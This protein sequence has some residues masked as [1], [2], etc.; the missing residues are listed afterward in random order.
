MSK[1][2]IEK[3]SVILKPSNIEDMSNILTNLIRWLKR[4]NKT[5]YLLE[6]ENKRFQNSISTRTANS[7]Q[8][9]TESFVY[10][11]T[12]LIISL[13][14]DGTLLGLCRKASSK[15]PIFSVNLG[16]LGFIT[17]FEKSEFYEKLNVILLGRYRVFKKNLY[18]ISV[19]GNQKKTVKK[20]F[21]NDAV[22]TKNDL[23]R[24]F[25]LSV[26]SENENIFTLTGDGL[27]ISSTYGSTA[28]SLA[29]GGPIVH[30][31]VKA[32]ILTPIC[33]HSLTH[34]PL[35]IPDSQDLRIKVVEKTN[36][37][38]VSIDGQE[39][40]SLQPNDIVHIS[41]FPRRV[42]SLIKNEERTY[43]HTLKEKFVHGR[44]EIY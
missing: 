20:Y 17:E 32:L 9:A 26:E 41:K 7:I 3:I 44:R 16:R 15:V 43:Y 13:G 22:F 11:K 39:C 28:Y 38:N 40:I 14:G 31:D 24:M 4:R 42:V 34:R 36:T 27:I 30:P 37:V 19:E 21:F 18:S 12:D 2:K 1:S 8:Y 6:K 29:A 35:V 5:I 10:N 23:A 25:T 33:A